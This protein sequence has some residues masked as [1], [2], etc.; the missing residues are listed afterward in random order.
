MVLVRSPSDGKA[1]PANNRAAGPGAEGNNSKDTE[2]QN[3]RTDNSGTNGA[4]SRVFSAEQSS[5]KSV[6]D[7]K[8]VV[9]EFTRNLEAICKEVEWLE[10]WLGRNQSSRSGIR[11]CIGR[12]LEARKN[13]ESL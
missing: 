12:A 1:V 9:E 13:L 4:S 5:N 2:S 3:E 7:P 8:G 6:G 10:G 11:D